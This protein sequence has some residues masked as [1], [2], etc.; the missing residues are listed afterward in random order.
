MRIFSI[1]AGPNGSGKS[2]IVP[3]YS[4]LVFV[5]ADYCAKEH[6]V[7]S[8]MPDGIEKLKSAQKETE[9]LIH[10][11]IS[12]GISFTWETVF[13]HPSR[14]EIMKHAKKNGYKIHLTY[15]TT[16]HPDINVHRV[17]SRVL[18]GGH[19]VPEEKIRSRYTRSISFL[20]YMILEADEVLIY[21]NSYE[22]T[23]PT[24]LFQ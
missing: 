10:E 21:D 1:F 15:I 16:K 5:N 14:L 23:N 6:P 19:D 22:K 2:T 17:R 3:N 13:S 9:R 12:D 11:M 20:P 18:Q 24:L 8:K 4:D 7:I